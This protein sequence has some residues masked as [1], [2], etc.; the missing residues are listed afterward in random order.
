VLP[1]IQLPRKESPFAVRHM[2]MPCFLSKFKCK[3]NY[4]FAIKPLA[5]VGLIIAAPFEATS[6]F[7]LPINVLAKIKA[8]IDKSF[9]SMAM[10]EVVPPFTLESIAISVNE[11]SLSED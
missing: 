3:Y 6:P 4:F 11:D 10:F 2:P 5:N 7:R 8:E 9:N 1:Q